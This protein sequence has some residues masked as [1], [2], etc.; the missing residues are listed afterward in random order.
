[1]PKSPKETIKIRR[2]PPKGATLRIPVEVTRTGR[3]SWDTGDTITIR[4]HGFSTP[5]T[6]SAEH[7]LKDVDD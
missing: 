2:L 5:V 6:V 7:L 3:N 1:M 4:I